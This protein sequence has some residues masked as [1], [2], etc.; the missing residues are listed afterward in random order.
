MREWSGEARALSA[1]AALTVASAAGEAGATTGAGAGTS[2]A[3]GGDGAARAAPGTGTGAAT[4]RA[5]A[6]RLG[7]VTP[8]V[9]ADVAAGGMDP[10]DAATASV[11]EEPL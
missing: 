3:G 4:G 11:S 1:R 5:G 6:G 9:G 7:C 8:P 2:R 10:A